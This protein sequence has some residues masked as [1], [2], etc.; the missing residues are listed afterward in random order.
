[1]PAAIAPP[2]ADQDR[3]AARHDDV[4]AHLNAQQREAVSHGIGSG[5][6]GSAPLLVIA[7]AGTGKTL[8]LAS[9][10]AALV[11][12]GA[13]PQRLLLLTFSRRAA[14]EMQRRVA[15]ALQQALGW[16]STQRAPTLPWAGTFHAI[17][18]RLLRD[19]AGR[20]GLAEAFTIVDR[21]D[22]EDLMNLVRQESG[23]A[24]THKRFPQ[25]ATCLAIYSRVR[26]QPPAAARRAAAGLP[27]VRRVAR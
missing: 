18:A 16:P 10:A 24:K 14:Q 5:P 26:Q 11:L 4:F 19:Y 13:D 3:V 20:I 12:A 8:T 27:L 25:K 7:G 22:A 15:R 23:L 6:R 1:M 17:G 2:A 9:R 21:S